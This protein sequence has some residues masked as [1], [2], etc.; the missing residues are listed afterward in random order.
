MIISV[1]FIN[2]KTEEICVLIFSILFWFRMEILEK[3]IIHLTKLV[4]NLT[5]ENDTL[6]EMQ[7]NHYA[8]L[9]KF[10]SRLQLKSSRAEKEFLDMKSICQRPFVSSSEIMKTCIDNYSNLLN[11][12]K[13]SKIRAKIQYDFNNE[14]QQ[15]T[16]QQKMQNSALLLDLECN[17]KEKLELESKLNIQNQM[18]Q[19]I[20]ADIQSIRQ[21]LFLKTKKTFSK[22]EPIMMKEAIFDFKRISTDSI[23][24]YSLFALAKLSYFFEKLSLKSKSLSV[25]FVDILIKNPLTL[26]PPFQKYLYEFSVPP[27]I[28]I[29]SIKFAALNYII[30]LIEFKKA[31]KEYTISC[32]KFASIALNVSNVKIAMQKFTEHTSLEKFDK[33]KVA[34]L[35]SMNK[36]HS[37][38]ISIVRL[39]AKF[40]TIQSQYLELKSI[41]ESKIYQLENEKSKINAV[42]NG[43]RKDSRYTISIIPKLNFSYPKIH[44]APA[45]VQFYRQDLNSEL[46]KMIKL[47]KLFADKNLG[48]SGTIKAIVAPLKI[49]RSIRHSI[50]ESC[51][52][53]PHFVVSFDF[54][55]PLTTYV[56]SP[57]KLFQI[58]NQVLLKNCLRMPNLMTVF[59]RYE[60]T[61]DALITIKYFQNHLAQL[62]IELRQFENLQA[63]SH[64]LVEQLMDNKKRYS[65]LKL[66]LT[67]YSNLV[68]KTYKTI[69]PLKMFKYDIIKG[70]SILYLTTRSLPVLPNI[71]QITAAGNLN[72]TNMLNQ[73][74]NQKNAEPVILKEL[75]Q[76]SGYNVNRYLIYKLINSFHA[77]L[78]QVLNHAESNMTLLRDS[79][80]T[81]ISEKENLSTSHKDALD[82][83]SQTQIQNQSMIANLQ[84]QISKLKKALKEKDENLYRLFNSNLR[85]K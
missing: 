74:S 54:K 28:V 21:Q 49:L 15:M 3:R 19:K 48:L 46:F 30:E 67:S 76:F 23:K 17:I 69:L 56:A 11:D 43:F 20:Y 63:S 50:S 5:V 53:K 57:K 73:I 25:R 81:L 34:L 18:I 68:V 33:I 27:E 82:Q 39:D 37:R 79:H 78:M 16:E 58:Q 47:L 13:Q 40:K 38:N 80:M 7:S 77:K 71:F 51:H 83:L 61:F 45:S 24:K 2:N 10:K 65:Q 66:R 59:F 62:N 8:T 36:L 75:D 41:A 31:M 52:R 4:Y 22:I 64:N 14:L 26:K 9:I 6:K 72:L 12:L 35:D 42:L 70:K 85:I 84:F 29:D 1:P 32:P 44:L 55:E 60:N